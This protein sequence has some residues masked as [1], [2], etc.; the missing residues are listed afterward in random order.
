MIIY[1]IIIL[2]FNIIVF[3]YLYLIF[4]KQ[5]ISTK[6]MSDENIANKEGRQVVDGSRSNRNTLERAFTLLEF[7]NFLHRIFVSF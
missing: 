3:I 4:L 2:I 1:L 5:F 7:S 6:I